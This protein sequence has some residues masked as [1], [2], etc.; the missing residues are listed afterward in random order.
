VTGILDFTQKYNFTHKLD[1]SASMN[2]DSIHVPHHNF[3]TMKR[4]PG[5]P[6][7]QVYRLNNLIDEYRTIQSPSKKKLANNEDT[8]PMSFKLTPQMSVKPELML[9]LKTIK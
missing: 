7:E 8:S 4:G 1:Q 3:A 9:E 6:S 2:E 5:A